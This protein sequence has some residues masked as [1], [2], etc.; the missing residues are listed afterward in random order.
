[1]KAGDHLAFVYRNK[2]E[3]EDTVT[4]FI[5]RGIDKSGLNLLLVTE[6]EATEYLAYL[7]EQ[8]IEAGDKVNAGNIV[9]EPIDGLLDKHADFIVCRLSGVVER[10][11]RTA[12]RKNK[13]G[14]NVIGRLAG[15]LANQGKYLEC[16]KVETYW[17]ERLL[18]AATTSQ[19]ITLLCPYDSISIKLET[20]LR[21]THTRTL[22]GHN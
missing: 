19:P 8:G 2:I 1:M 10:M 5:R 4:E 3:L 17:H 13:R 14:L 9:V 7:R 6:E 18:N 21:K 11:L 20:P 12:T 15:N 22:S 16:I